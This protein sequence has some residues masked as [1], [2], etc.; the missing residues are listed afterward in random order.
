MSNNSYPAQAACIDKTRIIAGI[1][2]VFDLATTLSYENDMLRRRVG[3]DKTAAMLG[4]GTEK[5]L[6][7]IVLEIGRKKVLEESIYSWREAFAFRKESTGIVG[8]TDFDRWVKSKVRELPRFMSMDSFLQYFDA[9]L[10]LLYEEEKKEAIEAF[11]KKEAEKKPES[12]QP[13]EEE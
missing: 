10:H 11:E 13:S 12:Q 2:G 5:T 1:I 9:E 3:D 7:G 6:D 4:K 8:T